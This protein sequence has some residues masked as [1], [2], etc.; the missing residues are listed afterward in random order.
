MKIQLYAEFT[1]ENVTCYDELYDDMHGLVSKYRGMKWG[2]S[3]EG[4]ETSSDLISIYYDNHE[5]SV[6]FEDKLDYIVEHLRE[7][8]Y[9][10]S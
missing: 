5:D 1:I 9:I 8:G 6:G 10:I 7:F 2:R 4:D 3:D